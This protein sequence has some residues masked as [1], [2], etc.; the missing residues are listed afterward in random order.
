[1]DLPKILGHLN[2][3]L[4]IL[5]GIRLHSQRHPRFIAEFGGLVAEFA[6]TY[7]IELGPMCDKSCFRDQATVFAVGFELGTLDTLDT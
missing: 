2:R 3:M 4:P 7:P 1:M 6:P 5:S